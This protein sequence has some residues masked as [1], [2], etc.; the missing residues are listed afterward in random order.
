MLGAHRVLL[1]AYET[2]VRPLLARLRES[3]RRRGRPGRGLP[4][5]RARGA[6][7]ASAARRTS[8]APTRRS[9]AVAHR[10]V[11]DMHRRRRRAR[12]REGDRR[13]PRA[14]RARGRV[15][16]GADVLRADAHEQR[17][18]EGG[19]RAGAAVRA[20]V[21]RVRDDRLALVVVRRDGAASLSG[22]RPRAGCDRRACLRAV[23]AARP[24]GSASRTSAPRSRSASP[25]TRPATRCA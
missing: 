16:G 3:A 21:R 6:L 23:R 10:A 17:L 12:G 4:C 18:P 7:A 25:T 11:R 20:G 8:R 24:N 14:A 22:A 1:D 9:D 19:S 13:R 2:D 15:P 5:R